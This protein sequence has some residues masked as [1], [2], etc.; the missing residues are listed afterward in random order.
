MSFRGIGLEYIDIILLGVIA[1]FIILRLRSVLGRRDGHQGPTRRFPPVAGP[2]ERRDGPNDD[3]V[4]HLPGVG[5]SE[6][7]EAVPE[8]QG[9]PLPSGLA[10]I[11]AADGQF[12][13]DDFLRGAKVAFEMIIGAFAVGDR[14][15][16]KG[17]LEREVFE[18]FSRAIRERERERQVLERTIVAIDGAEAVEAY[19]DGRR[20]FVTVR[21]TSRQMSALR[22]E[23]GEVIEGDPSAVVG[24]V[25]DWTFSRTTGSRDPN[26]RLVATLSAE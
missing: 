5:P 18:D 8:D 17:L 14:D 22:D 2:G 1:V 10:A 6:E 7:P 21:F 16:L 11:R 9:L 12:V 4:V 26:W 24:V 15:A 13:L 19:M 25:D 23:E 20:A 3:N